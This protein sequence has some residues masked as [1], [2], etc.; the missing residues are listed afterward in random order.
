MG[1]ADSPLYICRDRTPPPLLGS[2][3]GMG[4]L[5][6]SWSYADNFR[7]LARGADC[8]NV[9]LARL[10]A[11]VKRAGLDVDDLSLASGTSDVL[12]YEVSPANSY[13]SGTGKRIAR[14]RSVARTISSRR[15]VGR[16]AMELVNRHE[17]FLALINRGALN[18]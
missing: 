18:P 12:G 13:C 16:R 10:I 8:S 1:R 2:K 15:R 6:F 4:P 3:H 9:H 14:I 11:G 5:C 17:S 7:V